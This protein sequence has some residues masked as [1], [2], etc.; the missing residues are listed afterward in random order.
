[1]IP[2]SV[3]TL[4]AFLLLIAPGIIWENRKAGHNPGRKE[5]NLIEASRIIL[6]SLVATSVSS[7]IIFPWVWMPLYKAA[8]SD[9]GD[10]AP[11]TKLTYFLAVYLTSV[12]A[13]LITFIFGWFKLPGRPP[14]DGA[15][16]WHKV[17]VT[18]KDPGSLN[19]YIQVDLIDGACWRGQLKTFDADLDDTHRTL[20]IGQPL[21]FKSAPEAEFKKINNWDVAIISETQVKSIKVG[22]APKKNS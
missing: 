14:I 18:W 19:P 1:M 13:C 9:E 4:V 10:T 6:A 5:S 20:A 11:A 2:N 7:L 8:L 21:R 15:R 22:Y 17:F 12:V 16:V 3:A